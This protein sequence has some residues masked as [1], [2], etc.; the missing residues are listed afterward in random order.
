MCSS[1]LTEVFAALGEDGAAG[2]L[3]QLHR[4]GLLGE[5]FPELRGW[6][7][8][9]MGAESSLLDH[10]LRTVE[11]AE[12][13]LSHLRALFPGQALLL[14]NHFSGTEEEGVARAALFKFAAFLHD[15]GKAVVPP[16][17]Q[18]KLPARYP[19][20]DQAGEKINNA[21]ARRMKLSR[22][23]SRIL[24]N[25]TR[26]HMRLSSLAKT[27]QV[28]VRAKFRFFQDMGREGLDLA[29]LALANSLAAG[30]FQFRLPPAPSLPGECGKIKE[31]AEELL[32]Y[33]AEDFTRR[34]GRP[35]LDGTEV[36]KAL[37]I[38]GGKRVGLLL[39]KLREAEISGQ[40]RTREEALEFL[41]TI[42]SSSDGE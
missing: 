39:G 22:R 17:G 7:N 27:G 9:A 36:M 20:H 33:Y 35:L 31:I 28:T 6:E 42:P 41:K 11:A 15:S 12:F 18:G 10:A 14:K 40:V 4:A 16:V 32:R 26:Q 29:L 23:S 30:A 38:P 37:G 8:L 2:F 3:R 5:I 34:P 25:L 24:S 21:V 13:I 1:D 19:D